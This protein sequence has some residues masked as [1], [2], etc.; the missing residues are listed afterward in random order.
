MVNVQDDAGKT[1]PT[2]IDLDRTAGV[3][4]RGLWHCED[5]TIS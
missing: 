3:C 1:R 5:L 2:P 4:V